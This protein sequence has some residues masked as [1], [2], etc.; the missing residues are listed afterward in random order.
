LP[1][2]RAEG[3]TEPF[4]VGPVLVRPRG[5]ELLHLAEVRA[6]AEVLPLA[7]EHEHAHARVRRRGVEGRAQLVEHRAGQRVAD[8]GTVQR[9]AY[10]AAGPLEFHEPVAHV[11]S[12]HMRYTP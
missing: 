7:G 5:A 12:G 3:A 2:T 6:G 10:H 8:L 1:C 9:H 11:P 4:G